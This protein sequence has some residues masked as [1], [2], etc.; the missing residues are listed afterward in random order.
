MKV[1][2]EPAGALDRFGKRST[3][4]SASVDERLILF[5]QAGLVLRFRPATKEDVDLFREVLSIHKP[6]GNVRRTKA[7]I[8]TPIINR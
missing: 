5:G 1:T 6:A 8:R 3:S 4:S 2:L 7:I